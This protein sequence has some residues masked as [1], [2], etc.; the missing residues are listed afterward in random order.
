MSDRRLLGGDRRLF[1]WATTSARL[2]SGT[3]VAIGFVIA[4][5]TAVS[6][7][8]PPVVREP[9]RIDVV[10]VPAAS[11][12]VCDGSLLAIGRR[13]EQ[14]D[15]LSVAAAAQLA[16]GAP[17][18]WPEAVNSTLPSPDVAD[19]E[20]APVFVAEP[21]SGQRSPA[22]FASSATVSAPDLRGFAASDCRAPSLESWLVGGSGLLGA[23]DLLSLSNPGDVPAAIEVTVHGATGAAVP[24]GGRLVVPARTQRVLPL[25]GLALGEEQPVLRVSATGAPVQASLQ[26]SMMRT[27]IPGGVDQVGSIAVPEATLTVTGVTVLEQRGDAS[28][29]TTIVRMLSPSA[30]ATATVTVTRADSGQPV[31]EPRTVA[32]TGGIPAELALENLQAGTFTVHVEATAAIVGAVW[33]ATGFGEGADFAWHTPSG[34]IDAPTR[35]ASA[36]GPGLRLVLT[37]QAADTVVQIASADGAFTTEV[38]VAAGQTAEV[39]IPANQLFTLDPGAA[40]IRAAVSYATES[41]LGAY[42]VMPAD[43]AA[44]AIA[45][46]P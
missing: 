16:G 3:L 1:R 2:L 26:T 6:V 25:A 41:A 30:D 8:W 33:N 5:V 22:A 40:G 31:G 39:R 35:F 38:A 46:Y 23:A 19:A 15:E 9:V 20:G 14:A 10:P 21:A 29:A 42:P 4:V 37:G 7:P 12:L 18:G 24:P 13:A 32:L 44:P 28:D 17:E 45:V 11:V 34:L 43:A 36:V 27:L